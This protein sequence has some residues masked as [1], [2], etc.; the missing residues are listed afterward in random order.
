[1][2]TV[3]LVD[4]QIE[5]RSI[6]GAYLQLHGIKVLTAGDGDGAL[7]VAQRHVPDVIVL[8]HSLPRRTGVEIA[9]VL[10]GTART[11]KIPIIMMTAHSYGAVGKKAR[12][13]GCASFLAKP[14]PPSRVLQEI[15]RFAPSAA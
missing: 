3:L 5:M 14:C 9:R 15:Q 8:D 12:E 1:M 13:A 7:E 6:H 2:T 10:R 11:A 4:D